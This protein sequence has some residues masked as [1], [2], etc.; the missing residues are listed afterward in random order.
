MNR[1]YFYA[2]LDEHFPGMKERYR[3]TYGNAYELPVLYLE[4]GVN[5]RECRQV[6]VAICNTGI[7]KEDSC[8]MILHPGVLEE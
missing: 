8:Q 6:I 4:D 7:A 1:Q 2:K 5:R 3:K